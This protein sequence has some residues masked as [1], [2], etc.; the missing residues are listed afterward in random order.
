MAQDVFA[1]SIFSIDDVIDQFTYLD[2]TITS[3]LSLDMEIDKGIAKAVAAVVAKMSKSVLNNSQLTLHNKL[4]LFQ[5][6]LLCIL[7]YDSKT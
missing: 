1:S 3:N 4:K 6:C 5:A 2:S 7:F